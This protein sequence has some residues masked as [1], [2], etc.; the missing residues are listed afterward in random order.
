LHGG[1]DRWEEYEQLDFV[2]EWPIRED[3]LLQ[4]REW[5]DQSLLTGEQR[6]RYADMLAL[7]DRHRPTLERLLEE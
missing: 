7:I 1:W 4:L 2:I 5:D 3:R 6:T